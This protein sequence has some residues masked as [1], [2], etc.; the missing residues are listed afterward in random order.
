MALI[1]HSPMSPAA[2]S[3]EGRNATIG[4]IQHLTIGDV[5]DLRLSNSHG[6]ESGAATVDGSLQGDRMPRIPETSGPAGEH[7][8]IEFIDGNNVRKRY[9]RKDHGLRGLRYRL[10]GMLGGSVPVEQ[11]SPAARRDFEA[12]CLE[13][14]DSRGFSVPVPAKRVDAVAELIMP[15]I[16]GPTL[17]QVLGD[18]SR[19][20]QDKLEHVEQVFEEMRHRHCWAI[21][22]G[23]HRLVHYD[24]NTRNIMFA[25]RGV[26]RIDFEM[27]RL[28]EKIDRSAAREVKKVTIEIINQIGSGYAD[29]IM[30]LLVR[31]YGIRHVLRRMADEELERLISFILV[32][33][34][35]RRKAS[36]PGLFTKLDLANALRKRDMVGNRHLSPRRSESL[37][38][39]ATNTSWDGKFYQSFDDEDP[40]G[41]DMRH[42][43][44]I[45]QFPDSLEGLSVLDLGCNL[46]RICIDAMDRGASRAVGIDFRKDVMDAVNAYCRKRGN[47]AEFYGVDVNDGAAA[48]KRIVGEQPFDMVFA[49]AIW[50]HVDQKEL[51]EIIDSCCGQTCVFEDNAPSRVGNV[52]AVERTLRDQLSFNEVEFLGFTCDRGIRSVFRLQR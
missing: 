5:I 31:S 39:E 15:R 2:G 3:C 47:G 29:E 21:Y 16:E 52:A 42:R 17:Q 51:W 9:A 30:N 26:T 38:E 45:M 7:N 36:S 12:D 24:S 35:R 4:E 10:I 40:R 44:E 32:R 19:D 50:S 6:L 23:E 20:L 33:N 14:W 46:G 34:D 28:D 22:E 41:R 8:G 18:S 43:Y 27:G 37:L 48:L 1:R 49:L 25:S 13:L 11:W